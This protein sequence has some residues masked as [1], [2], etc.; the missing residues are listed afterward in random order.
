MAWRSSFRLQVVLRVAA[1]VALSLL[2]A[3]SLA[4]TSWDAVPLVSALLLAML[5]VELVRYVES[6]TRE[7]SGLLRSVAAGDFNSAVPRRGRNP[8][9]ADYEAASHQLVRAY[10]RLD[11]QRAASAELVNAVVERVGTPLVCLRADGRLAFVNT[12]ARQLFGAPA[13]SGAMSLGNLQP[14]LMQRLRTLTDDERVR[15]ERVVDGEPATW[16]LHAR[17][18]RLLDEQ[19]TVVACQDIQAELASRDVEAWQRLTRVLSHEMMNSLT[20]IVTLSGHL[21]DTWVQPRDLPAD[22]RESI[23]VIHERSSGLARFIE[24]YRRYANPPAPLPGEVAAALLFE[25]A[26]RLLADELAAR[27]ITLRKED[28]GVKVRADAQQIEQVLINLLRNAM[29]A[30][31]GVSQAEVEL[32]AEYDRRGWALIHV[33]DNGP[34]IADALAEQVFMPFVTTRRGGEGIGLALSRQLVQLNGGAL[35][36][37]SRPQHCQMVIRLPA[38]G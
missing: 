28:A 32:R 17:Q 6:A 2:L 14:L 19:F 34:G 37:V 26:S 18:F 5:T 21:R 3:W 22:A 24:S 16:L 15:F 29:H 4:R 8:P 20:P 13:G 12:A 1:L 33:I 7:L 10:Q 23:E 31:E 9:F 11:L 35:N 38:A 36:L 30:L 27:N 25:N